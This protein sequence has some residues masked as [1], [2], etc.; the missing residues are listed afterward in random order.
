M[1]K[2]QLIAQI[3]SEAEIS[4]AQAGRA[5]DA[6]LGTI[7]NTLKSGDSVQLV[8]FGAFSVGERAARTGRNPR[9]GEEVAIEAAKVVKFKPSKTLKDSINS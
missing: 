1:N 7:T 5:F 3:A 6:M 8:G 2:A 4:N 9:T